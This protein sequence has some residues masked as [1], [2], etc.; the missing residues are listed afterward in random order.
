M[1]PECFSTFAFSA[2]GNGILFTHLVEKR[3]FRQHRQGRSETADDGRQ[4]RQRNMP[5]III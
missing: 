4:H 5:Q 2:G 3:I 1:F